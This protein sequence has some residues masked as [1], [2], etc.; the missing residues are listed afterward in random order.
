MFLES[1]GKFARRVCVAEQHVNRTF[2]ACFA[3]D[4][5]VEKGLDA[6]RPGKGNGRA[7]HQ[8]DHKI[9]VDFCKFVHKFVVSHR[10]IHVTSVK[11]FAFVFGRKT[12]DNND[13]IVRFCTLNCLIQQF[14]IVAV[15]F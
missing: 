10:Q 12:D 6:F 8:N 15:A 7:A 2:A 4:V 5:N 1:F 3:A 14:F 9:F 13:F 11:S